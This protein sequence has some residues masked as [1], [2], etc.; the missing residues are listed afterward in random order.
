MRSATPAS[1]GYN[2][3]LH[4]NSDGGAKRRHHYLGFGF[5]IKK[6]HSHFFIWH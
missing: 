2:Y 5:Q 1:N 3:V 6:W 4:L